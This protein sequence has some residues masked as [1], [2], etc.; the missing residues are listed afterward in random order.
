MTWTWHRGILRGPAAASVGSPS[1]CLRH[2]TSSDRVVV[3]LGGS[4]LTLPDWPT[5]IMALILS[6]DR[7]AVVVVGGGAVVDGLRTIDA[8]ARLPDELAHR[9]AIDALRITSRVVAV[10]T[11]SSFSGRPDDP[12][13]VTVLDTP[14]WLD[15]EGRFDLLPAGWHVTSDSIAAL[16]A[17]ALG[18][19]LVLIKRVPPPSSGDGV[20]GLVDAGWVDPFFPDA[21]AVL[22]RITWAVPDMQSHTCAQR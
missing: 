1:A 14:A 2:A 7:P 10:A 16:V 12:S 4:L 13:R 8:V 19:P 6:L 15:E 5:E 3:K 20:R 11:A 9:L 21:A 18:C 22:E 17:T